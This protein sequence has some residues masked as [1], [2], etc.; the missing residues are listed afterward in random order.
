MS[1]EKKPRY[2]FNKNISAHIKTNNGLETAQFNRG[3]LC[4]VE[5]EKEMIAGRHLNKSEP[6]AID[7][8]AKINIVTKSLLPEMASRG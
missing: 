3:D 6:E 7:P 2:F 1:N 8:E 5:L 4:P